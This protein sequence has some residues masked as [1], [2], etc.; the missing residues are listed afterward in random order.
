M[1]LHVVR[2]GRGE[3]T[4]FYGRLVQSYRRES[5]GAPAHRVVANLG[6]MTELEVEN[7]RAALEAS[8][9]NQRVVLLAP[10]ALDP[11]ALRPDA[12]LRYLD[13]A[14]L[15]ELWRE[16]GLDGLLSDA[17]PAGMADLAP[18]QVVAALVIQRCAD[19]GSKLYATRWFPR[20]ALPELLG[21]APD[22]FNNTRLHRVLDAL[23][24]AGPDLMRKLPRLYEKRDGAFVS[25][26][27]DVTDTWFVGDGPQAAESA[28][29]KEGLIRRKIGIVL[30]CNEH[31]FPLRWEVVSGKEPDCRVMESMLRSIAPMS[32]VGTAPVVVDRAM[33]KSAQLAAMLSTNLRFLTALTT[34]E[35]DSYAPTLPHAGLSKLDLDGEDDEVLARCAAEAGRLAEAAGMAKAADD[36]FVLDCGVVQRVNSGQS[37]LPASAGPASAAAVRLCGEMQDLVASGS[38]ASFAAAGRALGLGKPLA[39]KYLELGKLSEDIRR[40]VAAGDA[41]YALTGLLRVARIADAEA[42]RREFD[43]LPRKAPNGRSTPRRPA[44][45]DAADELETIRVRTVAYFNPQR[46]VEQRLHAGRRLARVRVFVDELNARLAKPRARRDRDAIVASVDRFLRREEMLDAYI[47]EIDRREGDRPA[48]QVRLTLDSDE[49]A[50]RRRYD[51]FTVLAAHPDLTHD[52]AQLC[53]LY[54]A[55]DAVEKDFQIIKGVVQLRPVRH[56]LDRK[57]RAHVTLCMLALLLERTLDRKLAG[58]YSAAAALEHLASCHLNRYRPDGAPQLHALT[59][60]DAQQEE[61]LRALRL[62]HVADHEEL[63]ARLTPR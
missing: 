34:T 28:K 40:E 2:S 16:W 58:N 37:R 17:M 12:N 8:R 62:R 29:T 48:Y 1:H 24:D 30:L 60:P 10:V 21:I 45:T 63:L 61:I 49:W 18:A 7:Y 59:R 54:R 47:V 19:P 27:L 25:L 42:Q 20:T 32:W 22:A 36:L 5:D 39:T 53:N 11:A 52:A 55:K 3:K 4:Y 56:R 14:V 35:F 6:R 26:F 51:G 50:R 33:G 41:G 9:K 44:S 43:K 15:L 23:D 46:F 38:V 57:V 31:G 13:V